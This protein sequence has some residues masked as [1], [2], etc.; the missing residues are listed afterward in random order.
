[1]MSGV[2]ERM[3]ALLERIA[4]AVEGAGA[5]VAGSGAAGGGAPATAQR[6]GKVSQEDLTALVQPL[7][8]NEESKALVKAVLTKFG[9]KRLGDAKAEQYETLYTEFA[10]IAGGGAE[11]DDSD[12][13]G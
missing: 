2:L 13:I 7:V 4:A 8:Q 12:L 10:A 3:E 9:L 6:P 5:A 1:M 11:E